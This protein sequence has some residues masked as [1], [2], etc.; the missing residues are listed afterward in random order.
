MA[1]TLALAFWA[2]YNDGQPVCPDGVQITLYAVSDGLPMYPDASGWSYPG[3][4]C[5]IN[6]RED[7]A[8][9]QPQRVQCA[10][11]AHELGH[12]VFDLPDTTE[13][14]NVMGNTNGIMTI[15]SAC[16]PPQSV[17]RPKCGASQE[18]RSWTRKSLL[19]GCHFPQRRAYSRSHPSPPR[20]QSLTQ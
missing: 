14:G 6:V 10:V 16:E 9:E 13:Q 7:M 17:H 12:A 20:S 15:P 11:I 5:S 4:G 2:P 19:P 3:I 18:T 1:I 8:T